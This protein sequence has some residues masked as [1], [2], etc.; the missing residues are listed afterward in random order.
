MQRGNS[1]N[2]TGLAIFLSEED[3]RLLHRRENKSRC[4]KCDVRVKGHWSY[5][6]YEYPDEMPL[7][8][9]QNIISCPWGNHVIHC[10]SIR[11]SSS[12]VFDHV[13]THKKLHFLAFCFFSPTGP[14]PQTLHQGCNMSGEILLRNKHNQHERVALLLG[15][16]SSSPEHKQQALSVK[17][18]C[19]HWNNVLACKLDQPSWDALRKSM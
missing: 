11:R 19:S 13:I 2:G 15:E 3:S 16:R 17:G 6:M 12:S 5:L 14:N 7:L 4:Q 10:S 9:M 1:S 8:Y 18:C